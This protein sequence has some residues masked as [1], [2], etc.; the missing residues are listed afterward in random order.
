MILLAEL[1]GFERFANARRLMAYLGLVP[2]ESSS[3][4]SIHRGG[5]TKTGNRHLRRLLV[6][7]A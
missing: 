4:A 6:E 2:S 3:G 5:I 1:H 7:A